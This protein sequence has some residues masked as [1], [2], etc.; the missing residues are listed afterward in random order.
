MLDDFPSLDNWTSFKN[1]L[2][3]KSKFSYSQVK[4]KRLAQIRKTQKFLLHLEEN[5]PKNGFS[6]K[7]SLK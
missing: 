4:F 2:V 6:L 3:S 7:W 1:E 5:A